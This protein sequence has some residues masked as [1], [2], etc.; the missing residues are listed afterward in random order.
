[1]FE[2]KVYKKNGLEAFR[3]L[4]S[5]GSEFFYEGVID[6][7]ENEVYRDEQ[8]RLYF[9]V[10]TEIGGAVKYYVE[11]EL[12]FPLIPFESSGEREKEISRLINASPRSGRQ[13]PED[14]FVPRDEGEITAEEA[15]PV[16]ASVETGAEPVEP[17]A[18]PAKGEAPEVAVRP[19]E[20]LSA[21]EPAREDEPPAP[22]KKSRS[23]ALPL[24]IGLVVIVLLAAVVGVYIMKP[25][26]FQGLT[27]LYSHPA[28]T[29]APTP[30]PTE[31]PVITATPAPTPE[32][33]PEPQ[34]LSTEA[35]L[36]IQPL[37]DSGN[38]TVVNFAT[39]HVAANSAG[40]KLRQAY[41]L[42]TF[43]NNRWTDSSNGTSGQPASVLTSTLQG[44]SKDYSVLMCAL[45][46]SLGVESRIVAYYDDDELGYYPEI[47]VANDS[48]NFTSA[49]AD[50]K[51][52]FGVAQPYYHS[53]GKGYWLSLSRGTAPGT[54]VEDS[55]EY[56]VYVTGAPEKIK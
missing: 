5:D 13:L 43:V 29:P 15:A 10:V 17:V 34:G 18:E 20:K 2:P 48:G 27:S 53:D 52:W 3:L 31:M 12:D 19:T 44:D 1:M 6:C 14:V 22:K 30:F 11:L 24:G 16:E 54:R 55:V 8:G 50:L 38:A 45:T 21:R 26:A 42:Y 33:T 51:A 56:A 49:K 35:M 36:Q 46:Q 28:P 37:V 40:N 9:P 7:N 47:L 41:D 39:G 23:L 25:A 32:P 4:G